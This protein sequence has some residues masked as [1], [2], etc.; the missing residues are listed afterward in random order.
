MILQQKAKKLKQT[1]RNEDKKV[2]NYT[3]KPAK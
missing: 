3:S 2:N 1:L